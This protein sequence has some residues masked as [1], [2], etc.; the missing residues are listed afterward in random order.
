MPLFWLKEMAGAQKFILSGVEGSPCG[1]TSIEGGI[2]TTEVPLFGY[3]NL[4][5]G[6]EIYP[7]R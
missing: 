6:A 5:K 7:E 1:P 4:V 2:S 3:N